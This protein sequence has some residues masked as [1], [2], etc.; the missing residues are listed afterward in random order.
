[1]RYV[2]DPHRDEYHN[3]SGERQQRESKRETGCSSQPEHQPKRYQQAQRPS[4]Q[5]RNKKLE[6]KTSIGNATVFGPIDA[7]IAGQ[8]DS[9]T[10][11]E[12]AENPPKRSSNH[13]LPG[14]QML[15]TVVV[16]SDIPIL[17]PFVIGARLL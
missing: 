10:T 6:T 9:N 16:N 14:W 11:E 7:G 5:R 3:R 15:R 12:Q 17:E 1:M 4:S 8:G 2:E 13:T